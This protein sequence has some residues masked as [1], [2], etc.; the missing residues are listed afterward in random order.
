VVADVRL[1]DV[2]VT[3][4][5]FNFGGV[6]LGATHR[7]QCS[8]ENP[9]EVTAVL[10]CDLT[11]Y[12]TFRLEINDDLF[13]VE[14]YD[15]E[16]DQRVASGQS[17][18]STHRLMTQLK[19]SSRTGITLG[20]TMNS[21]GGEAALY[22]FKVPSGATVHFKLCF[23]P[24]KVGNYAF[25]LP[26]TLT[27]FPH[28]PGLARAV[29]AQCLKPRLDMS[30]TIV[31]FGERTVLKDHKSNFGFKHEIILKNDD[32]STLVW[33]LDVSDLNKDGNFSIEPSSGALSMGSEETVKITFRPFAEAAYSAL[34]ALRLDRSTD[35]AYLELE[36]K[37]RGSYPRLLFDRKDV[38][39]PAVPIGV[40]S[41][42]RFHILNKGYDNLEVRCKLPIDSSKVP[43]QL[44]FPEG[45]L[46]GVAREKLPVDV[47]FISKKAMSFSAKVFFLDI[48]GNQF[49]VNVMGTAD[50]SL[51]TICP[52][53]LLHDPALSID[54]KDGKPVMLNI[55][56]S[57]LKMDQPIQSTDDD[58]ND[59]QPED[60]HSSELRDAL[61]T[62]TSKSRSALLKF[63]NANVLR[64][65][66]RDFPTDVISMKGRPIV[67]MIEFLSGKSI[68]FQKQQ[69]NVGRANQGGN[70]QSRKELALAS[71]AFYDDILT[72]LKS[73]GALLNNL[74]PDLLVSADEFGRLGPGGDRPRTVTAGT[75]LDPSEAE[76]LHYRRF[77]ERN[78]D[79]LSTAAW[80]N[81]VYQV[82]RTFV[83][84]RITLRYSF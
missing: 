59:V 26:I 24:A 39:L 6:Y 38:V 7:L 49:D 50:N 58:E 75:D 15:E 51:L 73:Y 84:N 83:L 46:L 45:T 12:P 13:D 32:L 54:A 63:L 67:E 81:L 52:F 29:I 60:V 9:S 68:P 79:V 11:K 71:V 19:T 30:S 23:S 77:Y 40:K 1:P 8:I 55:D 21:A 44:S 3:Q 48:D 10:V 4:E 5:E 57:K 17:H 64:S 18:A 36:L 42:T 31:D 47:T 34:V 22:K 82:I 69:A 33:D 53:M 35:K 56:E 25:E 65:P 27:G 70:T 80:M 20:G 41:S 16:L 43:I 28:T 37:G 61:Q 76:A 78:W 72:F 74:R 2:R 66:L 14:E 62:V